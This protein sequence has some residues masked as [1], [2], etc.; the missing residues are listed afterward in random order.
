MCIVVN[1]LRHPRLVPIKGVPGWN[2]ASPV[3][4]PTMVDVT[5]LPEVFPGEVA[6]CIGEDEKEKITVVEIARKIGTTDH[7]ITTTLTSRLPRVY[8]SKER[9]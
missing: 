4:G 8:V 5:D 1:A 2:K 9:E 6:I 7:E 3:N